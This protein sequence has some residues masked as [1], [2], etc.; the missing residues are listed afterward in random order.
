MLQACL[1]Y[2]RVPDGFWKEKGKELVSAITKSAPEKAV[3]IAA[4]YLKNPMG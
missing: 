2:A 4:A 1:E 3:E